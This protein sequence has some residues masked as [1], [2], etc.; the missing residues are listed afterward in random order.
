MFADDTKLYSDASNYTT[1]QSDI[2]AIFDWSSEWQL[3]FNTS[4]CNVLH[5]GKNNPMCTYYV[6][7]NNSTTLSCTETEKDLGV[8]FDSTLTFDVHI[9]STI[10]KANKFIGIIFRSFSYMD[11]SMFASLYKSIIR[12]ILEY[13]NRIWNPVFKRQSVVL[14]N[15]QR[16]ATKR[17][18][19]LEGLSYRDRLIR[20]KLPSIKYRR[21]RGDL[22]Q[23]YKIVHG[24]DNIDYADFF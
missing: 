13:G 18:A 10:N 7:E 9:Q 17:L 4:K 12:P 22:I 1:I 2:H 23:L 6:D 14:E 5:I 8:L 15:V 11:I 16:R 20:L 21:L 19:L 3:N 24:V